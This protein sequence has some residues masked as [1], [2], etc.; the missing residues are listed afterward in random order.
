MHEITK[1]HN[2]KIQKHS[3][4]AESQRHRQ[5]GNR[6]SKSKTITKHN[7][8]KLH[9]GLKLSEVKNTGILVLW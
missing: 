7:K 2:I 6:Y 5:N 3:K 8:I 1:Q 9:R 4:Q